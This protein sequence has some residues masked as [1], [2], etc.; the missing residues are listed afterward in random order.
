MLRTREQ[1][2]SLITSHSKFGGRKNV[3]IYKPGGTTIII[4]EYLD[5][6]VK[7]LGANHT[8]L[9]R[10]LWYLVTG[11]DGVCTSFLSGYGPCGSAV[12][13]NQTYYK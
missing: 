13:R 12:S 9:K 1:G 5:G 7:D 3:G 8:G 2:T 4:W 11:T 6:Y 10:W